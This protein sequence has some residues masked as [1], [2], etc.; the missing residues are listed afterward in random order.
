MDARGFVVLPGQG[1]M[2]DMSPGRSAVLKLQSRETRESVTMFEEAAPA[3]TET[4]FH[5]HHNSDEVAY[6]L[7][8]EI[9]FKIGDQITVGGPGTVAFMPRG[10]AHAWKNTGAETARVLFTFTPPEA[11]KLFEE[12][13]RLGRPIISMGDREAAQIR[14]RYGWEIV[15]PPPF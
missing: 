11:G 14:R 9:T 6:V 15:G 13:T 10:I 7:N 3:G 12:Q 2:L 5:L 1:P 4:S 8:G